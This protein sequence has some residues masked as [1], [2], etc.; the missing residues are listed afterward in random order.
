MALTRNFKTVIAVLSLIILIAPY[1]SFAG[2]GINKAGEV[3]GVTVGN[4]VFVPVKV[5]IMGFAAPV[6][7]LSLIGSLGD[8]EQAKAIWKDSTDQPYF[9]SPKLA[10]KSVGRRPDLNADWDP[11]RDDTEE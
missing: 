9:I 3:T 2:E 7:L 11:A 5:A 10:R 8:T 6:A 4:M 1:S